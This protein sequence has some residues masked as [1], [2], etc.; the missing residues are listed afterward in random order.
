MRIESDHEIQSVTPPILMPAPNSRQ[1]TVMT[2][3]KGSSMQFPT[4]S[5]K[6]PRQNIINRVGPS[7]HL[8][9]LTI[10][11]TGLSGCAVIPGSQMYGMREQSSV[12]L[13]VQQG[14]EEVPAHVKVKPITAELIIEQE[15]TL[16]A[17]ASP[18]KAEQSDKGAGT[19]AKSS[20][21]ILADYKIGPGDILS[22]T[23][24]DHPELTI[25]AGPYRTADVS[26]NLVTEDGTIYYPYVGVIQ[27]AGKTARQV[28]EILAQKLA[29]YIEKVQLDVRITAFRSK[30]VYLVGE[31][32]RP[33]QQPITDIPMTMLEAVNL[34]GGFTKDADHSEVLLTRGGATWRVDLQSLYEDGAVSQNI[35]LE[36]GDIVNVPDR[37]LNKVFVLGEVQK[38]GSMFMNKKRITLAEALAEAGYVNEQ[39]S[40]PKYIYV[41]RGQTDS[42]ELYHLNAKSPDA[43]LLADR[44][45]LRPRD[46]VF[47]DA[48]EV[49]RWNRVIS[50]V[51]PTATLLNTISNIQYPLF[52]GRQ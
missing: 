26:G 37:S 31:V 38:P 15:K 52:G 43:L 30:R 28:R 29:K 16:K 13:P 41:M 35:L 22:I 11:L 49:A 18:A 5:N 2:Y 23:V 40:N 34:A 24:W 32:S 36:P 50:N 47:V 45:P 3:P 19:S 27:V 10:V 4:P 12:P 1:T 14:K 42:P 51:L 39:T 21:Q 44:F 17:K 46:I 8:L 48:A 7:S 25:P 9:A 33:G 20:E 6:K